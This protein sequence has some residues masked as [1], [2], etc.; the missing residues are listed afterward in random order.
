MRRPTYRSAIYRR[1]T[2]HRPRTT[3]ICGT[4]DNGARAVLIWLLGV[5]ASAAFVFATS[6]A[7]HGQALGQTLTPTAVEYAQQSALNDLFQIDASRLALQRSQNPKVRAFAQQMVSDHAQASACLRVVIGGAG[8]GSAALPTALDARR[9]QDLADLASASTDAFDLAYLRGELQGSRSALD[10]HRAYAQSG[11][12][13]AL[14][15]VASQ[16]TAVVQRHLVTLETLTRES[17]FARLCELRP[18]ASA[19]GRLG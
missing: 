14:R 12:D 10:L 4:R 19:T 2:P 16:R 8:A 13:P 7:A 3:A 17:Q 11:A 5:L 18:L 6:L 9:Q 15:R 1:G